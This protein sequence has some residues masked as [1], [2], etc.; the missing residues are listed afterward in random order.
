[1]LLQNN[2]CALFSLKNILSSSE[3]FIIPMYQRNY[4]WSFSHVRQLIQDIYESAKY[5]RDGNYY[6]GT[7]VTYLRDDNNYEV[8]D[9]QQRL[10]SLHIIMCALKHEAY[11]KNIDC[12]WYEKLNLKFEYRDSSNKSLRSLFVHDSINDVY[13]DNIIE[14]YKDLVENLLKL[15]ED[16]N[17]FCEFF[18]NH[19][20]IALVTLPKNTDLNHYFEIMNNRGEQLEKHEILKALLLSKIQDEDSKKPNFFKIIWDACSNMNSIVQTNFEIKLR[21]KIFTEKLDEFNWNSF[22]DLFNACQDLITTE[23]TSFFSIDDIYKHCD[24]RNSENS[25]N[26]LEEKDKFNSVINFPNFLLQ[27]LKVQS[28]KDIPLDDKRLLDVF[29]SS[30][31]LSCTFV[32]DYIL[33]L[34]KLRFYFDKFVIKRLLDSDVGT[35]GEWKIL[36]LKESQKSYVTVNT[37]SDNAIEQQNVMLELMF[38]VSLPSQNYK[39]WLTALLLFIYKHDGNGDYLNYYLE[40]LAKAY[41]LDHFLAKDVVDYFQIIFKNEGKCRNTCPETLVLPNYSDGIDIFIFNY[42]DYFLWKNGNLPEFKFTVRSSI[43]HFYPQHP[44]DGVE[45]LEEKYLHNF[46][47]LCLISRSKNSR[48]SNFSP[49]AKV[50]Y[51]KNNNYDSIKQ[52]IMMDLTNSKGWDSNTIVK[53]ENDMIEVLKKSFKPTSIN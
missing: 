14:V 53:H 45:P 44:L 1:M 52:K 6:I 27:V 42:L 41:M 8:V 25:A 40:N 49:K 47:N 43:E 13:I 36:T 23:N 48:L 10:T 51:Y 20:K 37:F 16:I 24:L 34:L 22:D 33:M 50:D 26:Y 11:L 46:G 38:H 18:F 21:R 29:T 12:S 32:K 28:E 17:S 19:V 30:V 3:E 2:D 9:G 35:I 39:H 5:S 7:L 31:D 4:D 15:I